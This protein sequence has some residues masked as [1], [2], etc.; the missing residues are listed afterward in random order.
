M[1]FFLKVDLFIDSNENFRM[2][3]S[4]VFKIKKLFVVNLIIYNKKIDCLT[5][6]Y[7]IQQILFFQKKKQ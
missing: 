4:L 2:I 6:E 3:T 1:N 5:F 7:Q